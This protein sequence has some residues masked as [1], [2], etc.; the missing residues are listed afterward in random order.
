M[1]VAL[2]SALAIGIMASPVAAQSSGSPAAAKGDVE[3]KAR[4]LFTAGVE[5]YKQGQFIA[6]AQAFTQAHELLPKPQLLFSIAQAFRRSFD[7]TQNEDHLVQAVKYYRKYLDEVP[8]GGRRLDATQA[9]GDLR[10]WLTRLKVD[11]EGAGEMRFPTRISV[12][13]PVPDAV[14]VVDGGAVHPLP[15]SAEIEPGSHRIEVHA[16]GYRSEAR[17]FLAGEEETVPFDVD[18]EGVDPTLEVTLADGAEVTVDGQLLGEV[19]FSQPLSLNRGRHYVTVLERGHEPYGEELDFDFGTKTRLAVDLPATNQR[20]LSWGV[21]AAGGAG[22]ITSGVFFGLAIAEE[23]R[24]T[25]I[26]D[27]QVAGTITIDQRNEFNDALQRRDDFALVGGVTAGISGA[28][29]LTGLF[30]FLFDEP[31]APPPVKRRSDEDGSEP[32]EEK[33]DEPVDVEMMGAPAIGPGMYGLGV[34]GRF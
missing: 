9:L 7:A 6:A 34:F 14:V 11:A 2:T 20:R 18:L 3:Q 15:Y 8:E 12:R 24:A 25:S 21:L 26:H 10:P 33:P 30:L 29:A 28:V 1:T 16:K 5:A 13:S 19:P 27:Q 31:D 32:S 22:L 23:S 4:A 17:E